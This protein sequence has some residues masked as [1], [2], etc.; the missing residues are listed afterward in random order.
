[1]MKIQRQLFIGL[2]LGS[3]LLLGALPVLAQRGNQ[4]DV[5]GAIVTTGDIV[6]GAFSPKIDGSAGGS[7]RF[8]NTD[9]QTAVNQAAAAIN[10]QLS[11]G[12]IPG[13][14]GEVQSALASVLTGTGDTVAAASRLESFLSTTS[15]PQAQV[16]AL[17]KSLQG[18]TAGG[19]V[20][21]AKL[22]AAVEAYNAAVDSEGFSATVS[23]GNNAP[24]LGIRATLLQMVK[25]VTV[26]KGK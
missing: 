16:Q 8:V 25:A 13:F 5:T 2:A 9:V 6:G 22:V 19:K 24:I 14:A 18:L 23:F 11:Q 12:T 3:S 15:V 17:V 10:T 20:S 21:P 7:S 26:A 4:S 1:M